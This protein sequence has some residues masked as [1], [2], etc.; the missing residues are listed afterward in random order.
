VSRVSR[1]GRTLALLS[2]VLAVRPGFAAQPA[3]HPPADTSTSAYTVSGL[4][5]IHRVNPASD[6]V[7]VRLYLLGGTRQLTA[8]TAGIETFLLRAV[9]FEH[10][11]AR[12]RTGCIPT[13]EPHADWTVAGFVCLTRDLDSAWAAFVGALVHPTLSD[14][15]IARA[16]DELL[17]AARRRY[18]DP[19]LRIRQIARW[20]AFADHPYYLDPEG[21][22]ESLSALTRADL[23]RYAEQQLVTS[24]MLLVVVGDVTRAAIESLVEATL[25]RLPRSDYVWTLPPRVRTKQGRWLI[26]HRPLATNYILGYFVGPSPMDSDYHAFTLAIALLSSG[27]GHAVRTR[28]SLSYAAYA[29]FLDQAIPAGGLYASTPEPDEVYP[30]MLQQ[31]E[32]LQSAELA[33]FPWARFLDHFTLDQLAQQ[34]TTDSQAEALARAQLYFGD[35]SAADRYLRR[36]KA[37]HRVEVRAAAVKYMKNLQLAYLGDTTRMRGNW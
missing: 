24:R 34:M 37:V 31:I 12:A 21:L 4:R 26:E 9:A 7:A 11:R 28:K 18:S 2:L 30:I 32:L 1:P 22:E 10:R 8:A 13:L 16:R 6:V 35:H 17:S 29:P 33:Y 25:G 19:E 36:L 23:E 27:V 3:A 5:V 20:A 15:A 14:A